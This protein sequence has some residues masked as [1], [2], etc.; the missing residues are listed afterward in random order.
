MSTSGAGNEKAVSGDFKTRQELLLKVY[1]SAINEYRFNVNLGWDRTKFFLGASAGLIAAG[2]GLMKVTEGDRLTS[3][4]LACFFFI[5]A[6]IT[7]FGLKTLAV[8]KSYYREAIFTKTVVERELGLLEHLPNLQDA[9]ANL[10]IAVTDGQRD[11]KAILFGKKPAGRMISPGTV[12][13]NIETIFRMLIFIE[14][15]GAI[16]AGGDA[17]S[18][19]LK[20][21]APRPLV[22]LPLERLTVALPP[23]QHPHLAEA[24]P[25]RTRFSKIDVAIPCRTRAGPSFKSSSAGSA[26][27]KR[28]HETIAQCRAKVGARIAAGLCGAH[29]CDCA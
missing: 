24:G 29:G 16:V 15:V 14:C 27:L 21:Q 3:G 23:A 28:N 17:L 6:M 22:I 12:V 8:S 25:S 11:I 1:D 7:R 9:R 2:I 26:D 4:F 10:S 18:L 20:G 13:G 19:E 5:S